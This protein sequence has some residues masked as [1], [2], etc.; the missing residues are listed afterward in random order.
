MKF[1]FHPEAELELIEAGL[2]YELE[3]PGLGARFEAEVRQA[4]ALLL[5]QPELG[6]STGNGDL[7]QLV[8][9]RFPFTIIYAASR[10]SLYVVALAHHKRLPGYWRSRV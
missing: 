9:Y 5:E 3:V 6:H 8:L 4:T 7:R 1:E 10:E 2:Y